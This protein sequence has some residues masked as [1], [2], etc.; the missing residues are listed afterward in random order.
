MSVIYGIYYVFYVCTTP[1]YSFV[2]TTCTLFTVLCN[3]YYMLY[4]I[5]L[6]YTCVYRYY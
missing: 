2:D 6:Y 5:I 1:H 4:Y 3:T